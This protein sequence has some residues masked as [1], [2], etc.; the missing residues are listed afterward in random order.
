[1]EYIMIIAISIIGMIW[2][3]FTQHKDIMRISWDRV[4]QFSGF[5]LLLTFFRIAGYDFMF[6][7]GIIDRI[8]QMPPEVMFSKWT[9]MLVFWEDFFFGVSL[10]FIHKYMNGPITK[11]IKWALTVIIS[12]LFGLGHA[13]QGMQVV[14][15]TS[16][17]P[18]FIVLKY[19]QKYGFGTTMV[20]HILYDNIT[21]YSMIMLPYL[22]GFF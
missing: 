8:P 21:L 19:G 9:L 18:Y 14:V 11:Y 15:I 3:Q 12:V 10:Y 17:L 1:M 20:C 16:L 5:M 2:L 22:L 4:A 13:Y 7:T 6:Q